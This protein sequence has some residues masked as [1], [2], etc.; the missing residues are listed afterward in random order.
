MKLD[1]LPRGPAKV[2]LI[3]YGAVLFSLS[4]GDIVYGA[5]S[6]RWTEQLQVRNEGAAPVTLALTG[7]DA[8]LELPPHAAGTMISRVSDGPLVISGGALYRQC[9]W[10]ESRKHQPLVIDDAGAH[11]DDIRPK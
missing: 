10:S 9:S 11:C 8:H 7:T 1:R 4:L 6:I 3:V 5:Y 2:L